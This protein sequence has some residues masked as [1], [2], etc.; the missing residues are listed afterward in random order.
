MFKL[1]SMVLNMLGI[2]SRNIHP[3]YNYEAGFES[4]TKLNHDLIITDWLENPDRGITLT[5]KIRTSRES[6]NIFVPIIMT[7]GSSHHSRVIRSRDVGVNEYLVKPFTAMSLATRIERV[8]ERPRPFVLD[9]SYVGPDRRVKEEPYEGEERR[10]DI[11]EVEKIN[12]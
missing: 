6:P 10:I 5:K 3:A 12:R 2:P 1:V 4:F 11:P 7:A 9:K 8:T